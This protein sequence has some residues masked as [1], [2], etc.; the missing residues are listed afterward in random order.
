MQHTARHFPA[1][2]NYLLKPSL[3]QSYAFIRLCS[4]TNIKPFKAPADFSGLSPGA[5]KAF[6][7]PACEYVTRGKQDCSGGDSESDLRTN[8]VR[9]N[10]QFDRAARLSA[11]KKSRSEAHL[12]CETEWWADSYLDIDAI[13]S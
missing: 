2:L 5:L 3:K 10:Y 7:A 11:V 13:Q 4:M 8:H 9:F 1:Y 12:F 6:P